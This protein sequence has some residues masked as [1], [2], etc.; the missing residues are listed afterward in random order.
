MTVNPNLE[1]RFNKLNQ[2]I[3]NIMRIRKIICERDKVS[4]KVMNLDNI[5]AKL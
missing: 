1:K 3:Q 5:R 2:D 4:Q